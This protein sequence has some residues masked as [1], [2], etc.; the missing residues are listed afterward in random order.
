[1]SQRRACAVVGQARST[2]RLPAGQP[3]QA[4]R[5]LRAWLVAFATDH[6]RYGWK[7]AFHQLRRDGW[8][9]NK[10]R[11]QRLWRLEGLRV[12]YRR[13]KKPARGLGAVIGAMSPIR[14]NVVW[15]FDF[16]FDQTCDLITAKIL[17][18]VD[19]YTRECLVSHAERSITADD[20]VT[21]LDRL[22]AQRG[23]PVYVRFD[24]GPEFVAHAVA[25]WCRFN[26]AS[27]VFIDPGSP[28]QNAWIESFN[29]RQR[30][31]LLNGQQFD[32]LLELQVMLDDRRHEYNHERLHSSLGY[33]PPA[34]FAQAWHDQ[35]P[36]RLPLALA[37]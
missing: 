14:P 3:S 27:T 11:V 2:Q 33:V 18:G 28:W 37:H 20:V 26:G 9:V 35:H 12:P 5:V 21:I 15:A 30:D 25:D 29:G 17:N 34:E 22:A 13:R 32:S 8:R 19:E 1:M 31:E 7:R 6:P 36:E 10:K 23:A 4:E 16:Q 24:N